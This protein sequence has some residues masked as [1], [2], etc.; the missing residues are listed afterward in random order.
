MRHALAQVLVIALACSASSCA[1]AQSAI[2]ILGIEPAAPQALQPV[3]ARVRRGGCD[4]LGFP[5]MAGDVITLPIELSVPCSPPPPDVTEEISLGSLPAGRYRVRIGT[6]DDRS[7]AFTVEAPRWS[8]DDRSYAETGIWWDP[9]FPGTGLT[10]NDAFPGRR[11]ISFATHEASRAPVVYT[12]VL[13]RFERSG[14]LYRASGTPAAAVP[15]TNDV[16]VV[17]AG[18]GTLTST[19]E[20]RLLFD[21]QIDGL[22]PHRL[23][24]QRFPF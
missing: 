11:V 10:I 3:S 22:P 13:E 7:L 5:Q 18:R 1:R 14:T 16:V 4:R 19:A 24:L 20:G 8:F 23:Q 2:D 21:Y 6:S 15:P 12:L 17:A 9:R